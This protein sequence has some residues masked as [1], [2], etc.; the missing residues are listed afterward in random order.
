M[1]LADLDAHWS[2]VDSTTPAGHVLVT[3]VDTLGRVRVCL[4]EGSEPSDDTFKGSLVLPPKDRLGSATTAYGRFG[5]YVVGSGDQ[6]SQLARLA[7]CQ[8]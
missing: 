4:Y 7:V 3:G 8:L 1:R 2:G 5:G 6:T